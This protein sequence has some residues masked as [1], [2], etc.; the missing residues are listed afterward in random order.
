[1]PAPTAFRKHKAKAPKKEMTP[2]K[3]AMETKKWG[4]W[5]VIVRARKA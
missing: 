3:R 5:H 2:A 4:D 1:M